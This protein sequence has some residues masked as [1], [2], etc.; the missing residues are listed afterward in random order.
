MKR[1]YFLQFLAVITPLISGNWSLLDTFGVTPNNGVVR[2]GHVPVLTAF[3]TGTKDHVEFNLK[4]GLSL[5]V[6]SLTLLEEWL[7]VGKPLEQMRAFR[8]VYLDGEYDDNWESSLGD[9][10]RMNVMYAR[11][12]W[13]VIPVFKWVWHRGY[14]PPLHRDA[15]MFLFRWQGVAGKAFKVAKAAGVKGSPQSL[16]VYFDG[17]SPK[18]FRLFRWQRDR[19]AHVKAVHSI[20]ILKLIKNEEGA[21]SYACTGLINI[22]AVTDEARER[23]RNNEEIVAETFA[24]IGRY[25]SELN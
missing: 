23:L 2:L 11:R 20:P 9:G 13:L 24:K 18:S 17:T 15:N 10:C 19:S 25:L 12:K 4:L 14:A 16:A 8:K 3:L 21:E 1:R 7:T 5:V 22:D 6:F